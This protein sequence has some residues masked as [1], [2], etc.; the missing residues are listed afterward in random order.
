MASLVYH[1]GA[2]GDFI[3]TLPAILRYKA[4]HGRLVLLGRPSH[5][6]L[7]PDVFE[8][9]WDADAAWAAG[10]FS[11]TGPVSEGLR[12]RLRA[13]VSALVF[14]RADSP[15]PAALSRVGVRDL[16]RQDPFPDT[17]IPVV[18]YHLSLFADPP[19]EEERTPRIPVAAPAAGAR[20]GA[21][22]A[23]GSGSPGKNWPLERFVQVASGLEAAGEQVWW[24]EGPAEAGRSPAPPEQTWRSLSLT[25]LAYK[26]AG[27][28]VFVGNDSGVTH[29]AAASGCPTVA[30]F[31][32]S[33]VW[34]W[35]PRGARVKVIASATGS[36][37]AISV[38]DVLRACMDFLQN[39]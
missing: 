20:K 16:L 27:C 11:S 39:G 34:T 5:G 12:A 6:A 15:L 38:E 21:A 3:T 18:D 19:T 2:L 7:V 33:G 35:A 32:A 29:L 24:I 8:E 26:L 14:A 17:A 1:C 30:L 22:L 13:V 9:V 23:F 31:G 37:T 25:G 10:L 28:R 4:T 36:I